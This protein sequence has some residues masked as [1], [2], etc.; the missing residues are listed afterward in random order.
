MTIRKPALVQF[1]VL[2]FAIS[3]AVFCIFSFRAKVMARQVRIVSSDGRQIPNLYIGLRQDAHYDV[4]V[5]LKHRRPATCGAPAKAGLLGRMLGFVEPTVSAQAGSCGVTEC[6]GS[7]IKQVGGLPATEQS[8]GAGCNSVFMVQQD[9]ALKYANQGYYDN[10]NSCSGGNCGSTC[11]SLYCPNGQAAQCDVP[12]DCVGVFDSNGDP[13]KYCNNNYCSSTCCN[14]TCSQASDCTLPCQTCNTMT[15]KCVSTCLSCQVCTDNQ[16]EDNCNGC[17]ACSSETNSCQQVDDNCPEFSNCGGS[18]TVCESN[19]CCDNGSSGSCDDDNCDDDSCDGEQGSTPDGDPCSDSC[20]CE[21]GACDGTV[22][23]YYDPIVIDLT[24]AGFALTNAQNGVKFDFFGTGR[25]VQMPWTATGT[26]VGWL[27]LDR[28]GG[29][30][31]DDGADLFSNVAPQPDSP[32]GAQLGFRA[33]AVYDLPANGGNG[34]GVIDQRDAIFPKLLV[35]VDRNHNGI[36]DPGELLT[37]Q[38]AGIQSISLHYDLSRWTDAYGNQFRYRGKIV[39]SGGGRAAD[40][41]V[42]DVMLGGGKPI[43]GR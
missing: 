1:A 43:Q 29:G 33:L 10:G 2:C 36:S 28:S 6:T 27:A 15:N 12:G 26:A 14:T 37:M 38:Q 20:Q 13:A 24:G 3:V 9:G 8:C 7:F 32:K 16:C 41:Y 17:L 39:F 5:A 11:S 19:G 31:I 30:R 42:Y 25:P 4:A 18:G 40:R 22:C 34:D 23:G 21:S 35:W